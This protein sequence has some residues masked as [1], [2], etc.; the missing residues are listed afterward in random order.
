[1]NI[2][3]L[4]IDGYEEVVHCTD[5]EAGLNAF[6]AV[7]STRLGPALGGMRVLRFAEQRVIT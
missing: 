5:A 2:E 4:P 6:I 7:H 3:H 1:M